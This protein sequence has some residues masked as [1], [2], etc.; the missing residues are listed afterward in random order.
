MKGVKKT[1]RRR[2]YECKTDYKARIGLITS[3]KPRLVIRKTNRYIIAQ[4]VVTEIAQD[5]VIASAMSKDLIA[6]G[7]PEAKAGSLKSRAA[8]YL[9]GL[10]L[11]NKVKAK[12][13][14]AIV[15]FGMN[16]NIKKSRIYA[17]VKGF[18]D[19]GIKVPCSEEVLPTK[20]EMI[21]EE[22]MTIVTKLE[23]TV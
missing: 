7:W 3:G 19:A 16:R 2:R 9:T 5:K 22:N 6:K 21:D 8:A 1:I 13:K 17:A 11:G 20:E 18:I 10:M 15:D 4:L 12:Y 23:K 14:E